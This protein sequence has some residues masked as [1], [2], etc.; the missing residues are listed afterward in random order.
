MT[1]TYLSAGL[2]NRAGIV[3]AVISTVTV[4]MLLKRQKS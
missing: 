2:P 4:M 3:I 1:I